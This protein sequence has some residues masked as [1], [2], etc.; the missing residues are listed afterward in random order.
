MFTKEQFL[1]SL[2]QETEICKHLYSKIPAGA[3]EY[4][5]TPGQR[6]T[7]ELLQ[8]LTI[9]ALAPAHAI[10]F[11]RS[12][13][14]E[15]AAKSKTV[16]ADRFCEAMDEQMREVEKMVSA[17]K[18]DDLLHRDVTL[19]SGKQGKMGDALVNYCLKFMAAYKMQLF[20]Y[21]KSAGATEL[22]TYN[23]W[24]GI[25]RPADAQKP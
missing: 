22:D 3:L 5:P 15:D 19:F 24:M 23:C 2:R 1:Q 18:E 25:D 21:L 10:I 6:S 4:R 12:R 13:I 11:D 17:L 7:L 8:Y 16:A 20:L 14:Q 9:S